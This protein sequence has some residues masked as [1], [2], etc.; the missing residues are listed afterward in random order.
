M[1]KDIVRFTVCDIIIK[2]C[3]RFKNVYV[4]YLT[5]QSYQDKTYQ[6][7]MW[8][9][10]CTDL[11]WKM[12]KCVFWSIWFLCVIPPSLIGTRVMNSVEL[13]KSW[14][15]TQFVNDCLYGLSSFCHFK[16][17]HASNCLCRYC[18]PQS[19]LILP[20]TFSDDT[21]PKVCRKCHDSCLLGARAFLCLLHLCVINMILD[22]I[23]LMSQR[24]WNAAF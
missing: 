19:C 12:W 24:I 21:F 13:W 8:V 3:P 9:F 23:H 2:H 10:V 22:V 17:S 11:K 5:N 1:E 4:P 6:R 15:V 18:L 20:L 14:S 7:L 16:E